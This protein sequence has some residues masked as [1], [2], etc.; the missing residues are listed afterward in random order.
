MEIRDG[1]LG[2]PG[3]ADRTDG[4]PFGDRAPRLTAIDPRWTSVTE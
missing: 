2:G 3:R 1:L 4:L